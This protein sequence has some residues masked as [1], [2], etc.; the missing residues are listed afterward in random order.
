MHLKARTLAMFGL[1]AA[2]IAPAVGSGTIVRA[3]H[4]DHHGAAGNA[5]IDWNATAGAAARAACLAP[6]NDPLHEARMYTSRSSTRSSR[7]RKPSTRSTRSST[8]TG[9]SPRPIPTTSPFSGS[10]TK[11]ASILRSPS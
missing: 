3:G 2:A 7:P 10:S 8:M 1:V 5:A 4:E 6:T 9:T 11:T